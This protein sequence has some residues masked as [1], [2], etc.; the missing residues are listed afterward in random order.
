MLTSIKHGEINFIG[1]NRMGSCIS[2][3]GSPK[4]SNVKA[5]ISSCCE[6]DFL[7]ERRAELAL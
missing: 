7:E 6:T 3:C 4:Q 2:Y 5:G 1:N